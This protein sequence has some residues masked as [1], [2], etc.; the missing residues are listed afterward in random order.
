MGA[1]T[2]AD[3]LSSSCCATPAPASADLRKGCKHT[4]RDNIS[5]NNNR[6]SG[7]VE[8]PATLTPGYWS[9]MTTNYSG[10]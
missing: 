5:T 1:G 6:S 9:S 2:Q 4:V 3:A 8:L 10:L 7:H